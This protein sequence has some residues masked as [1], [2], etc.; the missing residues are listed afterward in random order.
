MLF[1]INVLSSY[2]LHEQGW[3]T[4]LGTLKVSGLYHKKVKFPLKILDRAWWLEVQVLKSHGN[5]SRRRND[6][7][8]QDM[9]IDCIKNVTTDLSAKACQTKDVL[10]EVDHPLSSAKTS[11]SGVSDSSA[12]TKVSSIPHVSFEE[13]VGRFQNMRK[14]CRIKT[15][16]GL[17]P[18]S[19]VCR[20]IQHEP[21]T[22]TTETGKSETVASSVALCEPQLE[23]AGSS[24]TEEFI[25]G[26]HFVCAIDEVNY[27][28]VR[29]FPVE[30]DLEGPPQHDDE[31]SGYVPTPEHERD[32]A[33][34]QI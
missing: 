12:D 17:G 1:H 25:E 29:G 23:H 4:R 3:E 16:D 30:I 9:E 19:Y 7:G 11:E 8:P 15:F 10:T 34:R 26:R 21:N 31:D 22:D 18:F 32:E 24:L 20:M 5:K 14:E 33:M 13:N 6:K 2:S 28:H 27:E